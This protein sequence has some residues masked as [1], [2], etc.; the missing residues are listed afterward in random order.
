M[1]RAPHILFQFS[2]LLS[3]IGNSKIPS[4]LE[5]QLPGTLF[6]ANLIN[7]MLCNSTKNLEADQIAFA[8]VKTAFG[9]RTRLRNK[10]GSSNWAHTCGRSEECTPRGGG[11]IYGRIAFLESGNEEAARGS[12]VDSR[13]RVGRVG[14]G[15]GPLLLLLV[16]ASITAGIKSMRHPNE[17]VH[18]V[19]SHL[20]F[21]EGRRVNLCH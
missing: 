20:K 10:V 9:N 19:D 6:W 17:F 18:F 7:V 12:S 11:R 21:E 5:G 8:N 15:R 16:V 4:L 2:S 1:H 3:R 14:I 13:S